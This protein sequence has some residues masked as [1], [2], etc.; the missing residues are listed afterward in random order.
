M[1]QVRRK[2]IDSS[3]RAYLLKA[4]NEGIELSWNKYEAMLPQDGFNLLGLSCHECLQGPCRLNPFKEEEA[5]TICGLTKE[6]LVLSS[7]EKQVGKDKELFKR[8][9]A[10]LNIVSQNA[11][12]KQVP[13]EILKDKALKWGVK[14]ENA[15]Q[16]VS[17]LL[18]KVNELLLTDNKN[19]SGTEKRVEALTENAASKVKLMELTS[20]LLEVLE[21]KPSLTN[22]QIG[23][24]VLKPEGINVCLDGLAPNLL[25]V[26]QEVAKEM[27]AE[28]V[29]RGAGAGFNLVLAGD[30]SPFHD[31]DVVSNEGSIE[32]ALLT[33]L[34]DLYI[35][36]AGETLA[37]GKSVVSNYHTVSAKVSPFSTKEDLKGLFL[38]AAVAYNQRDEAKVTHSNE[39]QEATSG[40]AFNTENLKANLEQGTI[41][42][43]CIL[44]GGST[45][46]VTQDENIVKIAK[47]LAEKNA[48]ALTYGNAAVTLGRYG[49]LQKSSDGS[50]TV[51]K[52]LEIEESSVAYSMGGE[53]QAAEII[54]LVKE[55]NS[56]KA[57]V[58]FPEL[59]S[60]R[61]LQ[62]ALAFAQAGAKVL[63]GV[64]LPVD[65]SCEVA[66][67]LKGVIEYC[68]PKELADRVAEL[69]N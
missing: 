63:T 55:V 35:T 40:Y 6:D 37:R 33:G 1:R 11:A 10:L 62:V 44:G 36:D 24:G 42:G 2:T 69:V 66:E 56:E 45:V 60:T 41:K 5:A 23:L 14:G 34:V 49:L 21:G 19:Y 17:G 43:L 26:A 22:R 27:E 25:T 32:F 29:N 65:G 28:A 58:V 16:I 59:S 12:T 61:D 15:L 47:E 13:G 30:L 31:L 18:L 64:K 46:K 39:V 9:T 3:A 8:A 20:D 4:K 52:A 68:E 57:V 7:L 48:L 38:R 67:A 54:R 53:L 51:A 50:H